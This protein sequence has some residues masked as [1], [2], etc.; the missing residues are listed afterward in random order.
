MRSSRENLSTIGICEYDR[1]YEELKLRNSI[2]NTLPL[3]VFCRKLFPQLSYMHNI[4]IPVSGMH[5]R[6][7]ELVLEKSIKKVENVHSI[8]ANEKK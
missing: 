8:H 6:S 2:F 5:C 4:I 1:N 3:R 7:C